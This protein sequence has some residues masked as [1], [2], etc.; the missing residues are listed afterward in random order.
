M[1]AIK[2]AIT[3]AGLSALVAVVASGQIGSLAAN[4]EL[5][6]EAVADTNGA[7]FVSPLIKDLILLEEVLNAKEITLKTPS[8]KL[9]RDWL[10]PDGHARVQILPKGDLS[11]TKAI[12]RFAKL[13]LATS[14]GAC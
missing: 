4:S 13:V 11:D 3:A 6:A 12:R 9:A 8:A 14:D 1:K 7:A 10:S 5:K 2:A